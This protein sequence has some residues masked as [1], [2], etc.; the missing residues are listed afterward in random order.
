VSK[1]ERRAARWV[2]REDPQRR[3]G[4]NE[5]GESRLALLRG[6]AVVYISYVNELRGTGVP[7]AEAIREGAILRLRPIMMTALVQLWD[8]CRWH[9][10]PESERIRN[11]LSLWS[12]SAV[13]S[14]D[15]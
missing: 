4:V 8:C 15:F 7:L 14:R 5:L 3:K 2:D 13:C 11:G 6:T 10:L 1:I 12:L 9:W